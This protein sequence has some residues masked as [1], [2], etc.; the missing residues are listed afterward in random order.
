MKRPE[1]V[2]AIVTQNGN[3]YVEGLSDVWGPFQA[4]WRDPTPATRKAC[5]AALSD[6]AI[7]MQYTHGAPAELLGPDGYLLDTAYMHRPG[8]YD[9]QLDLIFS[10][11]TNVALYPEFH[12][13]F[14]KCQ[15]P[16]LAVWGKNDPF[17][18]PPGAEAFRRDVPA[19]D[20]RF[21]DSGHFALET[22]A[23][24]IGA[25]MR[26]FLAKHVG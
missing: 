3:A 18:I 5:R 20:I 21:V 12:K 16:L 19:A 11:R 4:Y 24:E 17:F 6:E 9:I 13:Y 8:A 22:H 2:T 10:Y 26:E 15:P 1:Q 23:S 14:R 7:K 25:A